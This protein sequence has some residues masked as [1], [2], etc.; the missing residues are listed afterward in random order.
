M[1]QASTGSGDTAGAGES[2]DSF[3]RKPQWLCS[4]GHLLP[5]SLPPRSVPLTACDVDCVPGMGM[6]GTKSADWSDS[7]IKI[8]LG[9]EGGGFQGALLSPKSPSSLLRESRICMGYSE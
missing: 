2:P 9:Q 3:S 6:V 8:K 7:R 5:P 4:T 1:A